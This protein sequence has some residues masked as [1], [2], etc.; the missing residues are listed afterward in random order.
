[1]KVDQGEVKTIS[2]IRNANFDV[3]SQFYP[4][5]AVFAKKDKPGRQGACATFAVARPPFSRLC[6]PMMGNISDNFTVVF[7]FP[8]ISYR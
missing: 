2:D 5:Y 3:R 8:H 4:L 7:H 1:M 6:R